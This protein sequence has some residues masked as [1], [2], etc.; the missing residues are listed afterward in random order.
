MRAVFA[1][2]AVLAAEGSPDAGVPPQS[3]RVRI[4]VRAIAATAGAE[5]IDPKLAPIARNLAEFAKDFRW[6]SFRLLSEETFDLAFQSAAQMELPGSRSV[7]V[8]PR[9]M[10]PDGRIKVHLE[11]LGEHPE[12]PRK[13]HTD[14]SIQRGGTIFVGGLRLDPAKPEA[15]TL[16]VAITQGMGGD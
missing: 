7:Q 9:E 10:S 8:T 4:T 13:L 12:H 5:Q 15:G 2:L 16:L 6:R 11:L 1:A 3:S 14:Y